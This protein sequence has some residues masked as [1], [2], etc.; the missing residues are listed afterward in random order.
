MNEAF[1]IGGYSFMNSYSDFQRSGQSSVAGTVIK[2][3][4]YEAVSKM[5]SRMAMTPKGRF[6]E[7]VQA[8]CREEEIPFA[9]TL[10]EVIADRHPHPDYLN[11]KLSLFAVMEAIKGVQVNTDKFLDPDFKD[12]MTEKDIEMVDLYRYATMIS[13]L[14]QNK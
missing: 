11:A 10:F 2:G 13:L 1:D 4:K 12:R 7:A 14:L 8:A 6:L 3:G 5:L 9:Q